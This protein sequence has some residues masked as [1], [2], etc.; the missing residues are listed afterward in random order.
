MKPE[1][2]MNCKQPFARD[3][4]SRE[5]ELDTQEIEKQEKSNL[6]LRKGWWSGGTRTQVWGLHGDVF[7]VLDF[8]NSAED[9]GNL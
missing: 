8:F 6:V 1:S 2:G 3:T 9:D 7:L 4:G 5:L